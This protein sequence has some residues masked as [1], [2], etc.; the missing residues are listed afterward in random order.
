[1]K[2]TEDIQILKELDIDSVTPR[3]ALDILAD[4]KEKVQN[5]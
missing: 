5:E 3:N 2:K 4:L 1:M